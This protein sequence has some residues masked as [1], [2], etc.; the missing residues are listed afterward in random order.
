MISDVKV[1]ALTSTNDPNNSHDA[2][3]PLKY[4]CFFLCEFKDGAISGGI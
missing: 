2:Q 3:R 1:P 4:I